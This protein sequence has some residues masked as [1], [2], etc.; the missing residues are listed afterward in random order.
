[1]NLKH[2]QCY[3]SS[4]LQYYLLFLIPVLQRVAIPGRV[5]KLRGDHAAH[6]LGH[7]TR[8]LRHLLHAIPYRALQGSRLV[9]NYAAREI[10]ICN[11]P[12]HK[13]YHSI[14]H[15]LTFSSEQYRRGRYAIFCLISS[16]RNLLF[17]LN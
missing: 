10:T 12:F 4:Y 5:P 2:S 13:M 7:V 6:Q 1:M 3:R 9:L 16:K 14:D 15:G 11:R 17:S 8:Y